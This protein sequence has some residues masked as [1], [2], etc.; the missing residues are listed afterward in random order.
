MAT[1]LSEEVSADI[2]ENSLVRRMYEFIEN[3]VCFCVMHQSSENKAHN[4]L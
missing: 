3:S 2:K 1:L 4:L